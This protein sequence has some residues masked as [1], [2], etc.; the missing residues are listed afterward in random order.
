MLH[1]I[2]SKI[3]YSSKIFQAQDVF[4]HTILLLPEIA[5]TLSACLWLQEGMLD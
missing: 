4:L 1:L 5:S 3:P 2:I